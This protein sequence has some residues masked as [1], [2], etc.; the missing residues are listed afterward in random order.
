MW[1]ARRFG[2]QDGRLR[3][4]S[5]HLEQRVGRVTV[6]GEDSKMLGL[7]LMIYAATC[8]GTV[9]NVLQTTPPVPLIYDTDIGNDV[10]DALALGVIHAL[11]SR[12]ECKLLAVT[13]TKDHELCA[14]FVDAVNTFYGR[15]DI[16]IGV[17]RDGATPEAS[18]FNVLAEVEDEGEL[19]YP[20]DLRGGND[21][22]EATEL[23]RRVLAGQPDRSVVICQVGFSTNLARLLDTNPDEYS[24]LEGRELVEKKVRLLSVMA[25]DFRQSVK[26]RIREF[27]VVQDVPASQKLAKEWPTP[28]VYSGFE[29][30]IAIGYPAVSIERDYSY[31]RHHPLQEAYQL[32]MP[33]PHERPT[34]DLTSV[35]WAVRPDH[36]Y[37][38]LSSKGRAFFDEK[39]ATTFRENS[40]GLHRYLTVDER[41]VERVKEI[42]AAL[43]SQ[44][45]QTTN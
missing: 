9:E 32:Y 8:F 25:G 10:D 14:P 42:L 27:N 31:V 4:V 40:G 19:R 35:L 7:L 34:W 18:K 28:I 20:H 37:F 44:P 5:S 39:G 2:I 29:I 23:L 12:G 45:P 38:G 36:G 41:Q 24:P 22:P 1:A 15:G 13:I 6:I 11:E 21:A 17:V 3:F 43:A 16:P 30:G 26:R 33:T